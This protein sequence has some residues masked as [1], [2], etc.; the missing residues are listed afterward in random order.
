MHLPV[1]ENRKRLIGM[2]RQSETVVMI[3]IVALVAVAMTSAD[4]LRSPWYD[5]FYTDF[6][7]GPRFSFVT[8]L[9]Q[10]WLPDNHPP[11]FYFLAWATRWIGNDIEPRRLLN[12]AI[13]LIHV[14]LACAWA[15]SGKGPQTRSL[16]FLL[17]VTA[18]Y[19]LMDHAT[20][21]RS[22]FLNI[23]AMAL[24]TVSLCRLF[25]NQSPPNRW[26]NIVLYISM[27]EALNTHIIATIFGAF[28]VAG[29]ILIFLI[30]KRYDLAKTL[31]APAAFAGLIFL[32]ITGI[33]FGSWAHNTNEFWVPA[34]FR[35][36]Q[37]TLRAETL[38]ILAG[39]WI[40][41]VAGVVGLVL[42]ASQAMMQRA[43][44]R[45]LDEALILAAGLAV[46][47]TVILALASVRP[48][49]RARYLVAMIPQVSMLLAIGVS[50]LVKRVD[51]RLSPVLVGLCILASVLAIGRNYRMAANDP[52]WG[53]T[54]S[55]IGNQVRAC[56]DTAVHTDPVWNAFAIRLPP[57]DNAAVI[58][59]SY[60]VMAQRAHFSIEPE[61]S[62]R[63]SSSCPTLFWA[64]EQAHPTYTDTEVLT[65]IRT[66]GFPIGRL[67]IYRRGWGFV[68]STQDLKVAPH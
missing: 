16:I 26:Q 65:V 34:G 28:E 36:A 40:I 21:I 50:Y 8:A 18:Q 44:G 22:Y 12:V 33:Q 53:G 57:P 47:M 29:F 15:K 10:H 11:L 59:M 35:A 24:L 64:E 42:L 32:V 17:M 51:Q 30:D 5:E 25:E 63:M 66:R 4:F 6:V 58:N 55:L 23:C 13:G 39:N 48:L 43:R 61:R 9:T 52:G 27:I 54:A 46:A 67:F 49:L 31:I 41:A 14:G 7:T 2:L 62:R 45:D 3:S 38:H 1:V 37:W 20:E 56:P 60:A 68:A 19:A